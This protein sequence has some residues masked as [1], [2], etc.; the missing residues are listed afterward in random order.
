MTLTQT[1]KKLVT[2]HTI[3]NNLA[4][5]KRIIGWIE[6]RLKQH[7]FFVQTFGIHG[8]PF[9]V[10]AT[11]RAKT[12]RV[13]L[14]AHLDVVSAPDAL[15]VPRVRGQRLIARGAI[16]MKFAAACYLTL[17]EELGKH[18]SNYNLAILFTTDEESNM[19]G[20]N[21]TKIFLE[22]GY[23]PQIVFLPDAGYNWTIEKESKGFLEI[24]ASAKG[25]SAHGSRPWEG[26]NPINALMAFLAELQEQFPKEPC[27]DAAHNHTTFSIGKIQGGDAA[28]QIPDSAYA[29]V[30]IRYPAKDSLRMT[31]RILRRAKKNHP[32]VKIEIVSH[33]EPHRTDP[34]I[35]E[36]RLWKKITRERY[37][38]RIRNV[39]SHG[40]SDARFFSAR[41][42][43]V[44]LTAPKGGGHHGANE[45]IDLT[46]FK[47]YYRVLK[48]WI[49]QISRTA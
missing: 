18:A 30:N 4:E 11:R 3:P 32:A 33:G 29:L 35:P 36:I 10:A 43:P 6:K 21:G 47:R 40:A 15:F 12:S 45:W 38:I 28:N 20:S 37:G 31:E 9:L 22:K 27:R 7:P 48:E 8:Q 41:G 26:K 24:K 1:L 13:L 19:F 17:A 46:D 39:V 44:L 14:A 16:D 2:F 49:N 5:H 23:R 42:I 25:K 34:N